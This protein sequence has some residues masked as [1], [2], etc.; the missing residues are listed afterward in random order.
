MQEIRFRSAND[1][2]TYNGEIKL[3]M[4]N[5]TEI[6]K[7]KKN[8]KHNQKKRTNRIQGHNTKK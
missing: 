5:R 8:T 7:H 6:K 1:N 3:N 4:N 2:A